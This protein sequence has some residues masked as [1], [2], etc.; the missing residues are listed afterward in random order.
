MNQ[1]AKSLAARIRRSLTVSTAFVLTVA[2]LAV[3]ELAPG[4]L[5]AANAA[6]GS[7]TI[8]NMWTDMQANGG[9]FA[10]GANSNGWYDSSLR[11]GQAITVDRNTLYTGSN[12]YGVGTLPVDANGM[13]TSAAVT[14]LGATS[15]NTGTGTGNPPDP[16]GGSGTTSWTSTIAVDANALNARPN[17]YLYAWNYTTDLGNYIVTALGTSGVK[18]IPSTVTQG[19]NGATAQALYRVASGGTAAQYTVIPTPAYFGQNVSSPNTYTY[20]SGGEAVQQTGDIMFSGA[21][22]TCLSSFPMMEFDPNNGDYNFSAGIQP[23]SPADNI[24]GT[25]AASCGYYNGYVAS[26]MALDA[27]GN[28]YLLV[29]SNA[30]VPA[31]KVAANTL[32]TTWMVKIIPSTDPG[33]PW[34]YQLVAPISAAPGQ[35]GTAVAVGSYGS[36]GMAFFNGSLYVAA[37]AGTTLARVNPMS[38]QAYNVP[39]GAAASNFTVTGGASAAAT[40]YDLA[41]GQTAYVIQGQVYNDADGNGSVSDP[42][43]SLLPGQTV[44]LYMKDPN[45]GG[46]WTYEGSRITNAEGDY[47]FLVGGQGEYIVRLV[48]PQINGVNAVQ[49]WADAGSDPNTATVAQCLNDP[50][51]NLTASNGACDGALA[52]PVAD[53]ALPTS[54]S[55]PG[56]DTSTQ[57]GQ[58]P[59]YSTVTMNSDQEVANADFGVTTAGSYGDA[60]IAPTTVAA[61]APV[62]LNGSAEPQQ[63]WLGDKL[64][65][66]A[67]PATDNSHASTDDGLYVKTPEGNLPLVDNTM[68]A[69]TRSYDVLAQV[70]GGLATNSNVQAEAWTT[71][72]GGTAWNNT[73]IWSPTIDSSQVASGQMQVS[74]TSPG[75]S[76]APVTVRAEVSI[77]ATAL[78]TN[79]NNEYQAS[80]SSTTQAWA[81][82]GE[83]EDNVLTAADSV[84]RPVAVTTN[85]SG[86]FTVGGQTLTASTTPAI[87]AGKAAVGGTP[88]SVTAEAASGWA[89]DSVT[90]VNT[91]SN[92]TDAAPTATTV[93]NADG[94]V[95]ITWTPASADDVE[96]VATYHELANPATSTL[97][98][99]KTTAT[100]NAP[101]TATATLLG[102]DGKPLAGSTVTFTG[103]SATTPLTST[104]GVSLATTPLTCTTDDTGTCSVT[105]TSATAGTFTGELHATVPDDAGVAQDIVNSPATVSFTADIGYPATSSLSVTPAGPLVVTDTANNTYTATATI[106]DKD[107]NPSGGQTVTF[108]V[109][110]ADG[111]AIDTSKTTLSASTC[112]TGDGTGSDPLGQCS[113]TLTS[114]QAGTFLIHAQIATSATDPTLVDVGSAAS[115]ATSSPATVVFKPGNLCL[116]ENGCTTGGTKV[117]VFPDGQ[118]VTTPGQPVTPENQDVITATATDADGNPIGGVVFTFAPRA[119]ATVTLSATSCTTGDGTGGTTLGQCTVTATSSVA[120]NPAGPTMGSD[121]VTVIVPGPHLVDASVTDPGSGDTTALTAKSGSPLPLNF[122]AGGV[123]IAEAGCTGTPSTVAVSVDNMQVTTPGQAPTADNQDVVIGTAHDANGNLVGGVEFDFSTTDATLTLSGTTCTTNSDMSSPDYG[124]CSVTATST[125]SGAHTDAVTGSINDAGTVTE[126]TKS[127]SPLT[128]NFKPGGVCIQEAGCTGSPSYVTVYPD[129]ALADGTDTDVI[130]AYA[131]DANG[132]PKDGVQ[133]VFSTADKDLSLAATSCTTGDGTN[134]TTLGQCTVTATSTVATNASGPVYGTD[135][136]TVVVPGPHLVTASISDSGTLTELTK[137]G[138]PAPLNFHAGT[139]TTKD[140]SLSLSASSAISGGSVTATVTAKDSNGNLVPNTAITLQVG[141]IAPATSMSATVGGATS[142]T[143]NTGPDGQCSA[144]VTDAASETVNV[145]GLLGTDIA[146]DN[147]ANSPASVEFGSGPVSD[148]YSTLTVAPST[149][150]AGSPVIVTVTAKD[151]AGNTIDNLT[152]SQITVTGTSAGLPDLVMTDFANLGN[153]VYQYQTT[154]DLV[155]TFTFKAVVDGVSLT[156]TMVNGAQATGY[157]TVLFTAGDVCVSNCENTGDNPPPGTDPT[158]VTRFTVDP[159]GS[160]A[161]GKSPSTV[162]AWAYD[163]YGNAVSG[164]PVVVTDTTTGPL[165]GKLTQTTPNPVDTSSDGT[166]HVSFVTTTAGTYQALGTIGGQK[167]SSAVVVLSFVPGN[168]SPS[169]SALT[170]SQNSQ[171]AGASVTAQ[172][173][174]NDAGGNAVGGV[175]VIVSSDSPDVYFDGDPAQ[176][177]FICTTAASGTSVGTCDVPF[178]SKTAG[179]YRITAVIAETNIGGSPAPVSFT[180]GQ[181][182]FTNC[183]PVDGTSYTSVVMTKDGAMGNGTDAN[184]ATASVFD[185]YGNPVAGATVATTPITSTLSAATATAT[186]GKDGTA[187]LAYTSTAVG[188]AQASVTIDGTEPTGPA[189]ASDNSGKSP[190]TMTFAT[191]QADPANSSLAI[192][193]TTSQEVDSQF[194]VTATVN[195]SANHPVTGAVVTFTADAGATLS[196]TTCTT[197]ADGT[198]TVDVSATKVGTYKVGATIPNTA[199]V[200]TALKS[201]PVSATFTAGPVCVQPACTPD[202]GVPVTSV[203]VT[204]N[205]QANDGTSRDV[206]TVYAY[207][208]HGNPVPGA[209]VA[210]TSSDSGLVIQPDIAKTGDNGQSSIW[211]ASTVAGEHPADVTVAGLTPPTSPISLAFGNGVGCAACSSFAVAPNGPLTVG[212]SDANTYTVT[213]TVNDVFNKP[214]SGVTVSFS[215]D[216]AGPVWAGNQATCV[217]VADGTCSVKVS[218]TKAGTFNVSAGLVNPTGTALIG[219]AQPVTWKADAVCAE[220]CTPVDPTLSADLRTRVVVLPENDY[221]L[222]DG[223]ARDIATVYAFDQYGNPVPAVLVKSTSSDSGLTIQSAPA[224][225]NGQGVT[226]IWYSSTVAGAHTADVTLADDATSAV[227]TPAGSP[228]TLNFKTGGL[229]AKNSVLSV[230]PA[231]QT[232][233]AP[234]TVSIVAKDATNNP[235]TGL[236]AGQFAVTGTA[237]GLPDLI[238]G[239]WSD[240]GGG[241]YT[242]QTTSYLDGTFTL[243]ATVDGVTLLQTPTATFTSGGVCVSNCENTGENP[244]PGTDPTHV[245]RFEVTTDNQVANGTSADVVTAWAYDTYGNAVGTATSGAKV[246]LTDQTG[247]P[248]NGVLTPGTGTGT[249]GAGG[250]ATVSFTSVKSGQFQA[251]GTIDGLKPATGVVVMNFVPANVSASASRL[252]VSPSTQTAG[253]SVTAHV[254]TNDANGN[255]VGGVTVDLSSNSPDVYFNNDQAQ[256]TWTC[257]TAPS[258]ANLGTCDVPVTSKVAG[259]YKVSATI[260]STQI[261]G[262][263]APVTFTAGTVCYADCTPVDGTSYTKVVMTKDGA[264]DDGTD[265]NQATAYA[266]DQYGNPVSGA[267]VATSPITS[268]LKAAKA[269]AVTAGDGTAVLSYTSMVAGPASAAVTINGTAPSDP[270]GP[271]PVSMTFATGVGDPAHSSVAISPATSQQVDSTFTVTA[272]VNDS[273]DQPVTD[274]V[275]SF[276]ADAGA[277]LSAATCTTATDGTCSVTVTATKTGTYKIHATIPNAAGAPT[278]VQNS[279]VS[280]VFTAGPVCLVSAGCTPDQGVPVTS[281]VVTI[282]GVANDGVARDIATVYA[283]DKHGNAVP[284]APVASTSTS[285]ALT[286]Q[287]NVPNTDA[288]GQSTVWYT[289]TTAGSFPADVTVA[290]GAPEGSPVSLAFGNGL[291]YA[292]NSSFSVTPIGP[293]TVGTGAANTYTVTAVVN[294]V[295]NKP[296]AGAVASFAISPT[297]PAWANGQTCVTGDGTNGTTLGQCSVTVSSTKSGTF[298]VTAALGADPIGQAESVVWK[299]DAVCASDCTPVDPNLPADQR[300]RVAVTLDNQLADGAAQDIATLYAFDEYGNPV[301]GALVQSTSSD[302]GLLIQSAPAGTNDHGVTTIWY[303]SKVAG[304]HTADVTVDHKV[305]AGSPVTVN[306]KAGAVDAQASS[307]V[308]SPSTQKVTQNVTVTV[309]TRDANGNVTGGVPVKLAVTGAATLSAS[310][311]TTDATTGICQVTLTD[312]TPEQVQVSATIAVNG[313]DTNVGGSPAAVTFTNGC[314][315]GI[316]ADCQY[317]PDVTNDHRTNVQVTTDHQK[318]GGAGTDVATVKVFDEYGIAVAGVAVTST[319]TESELKISSPIAATDATG[320][321]TI[322]YTS[323]TLAPGAYQAAVMA[324]GVEIKFQP[325]PVPP[326]TVELTDDQVKALSSPVTLNFVDVTPPAKPVVITPKPGEYINTGTPTVSGTAEPGSVVAVTV[327]GGTPVCTAQADDKGTWS[328][329]NSGTGAIPMTDGAHTISVTAADVSGNVS[330]ATEVTFTVDTEAP[331]APKVNPTDGTE[332]SGSAEP[333]TTINVTDDAGNTIPGCES[334]T[335]AADTGAFSC[336]PAIPLTPGTQVH[337][338]ATDE[339]GNVSPE[340][341]VT[342]MPPLVPQTKVATG[343]TVVP[344][345]SVAGLGALLIAGVACLMGVVARRR[346]IDS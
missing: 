83:I 307:L 168:V 197:L 231:T 298:A 144:D 291:G 164:V 123:C 9:N 125:V 157:P 25:S 327:D 206:A 234:V 213:A 325:Q 148:R 252:T 149:Q 258:G 268:T 57:P 311:C 313:T 122:T 246:V 65:V 264:M 239:S 290:G 36:W 95:T 159:N 40:T 126:L 225:T 145:Y 75:T 273:S 110:N 93:T 308:A 243:G 257:L 12:Y 178:T 52:M 181:P 116:Q 201:S 68:V 4:A 38:G 44:A 88:V 229:S 187:V 70:N 330:G 309:T 13:V 16:T 118:Q 54:A 56:S 129:N 320:A 32:G 135:G 136:T 248:L 153:G 236:T 131:V 85:G 306:F 112:T 338:T 150:T 7:H 233:G 176:T 104:T 78:P 256:T 81:T 304:A 191:G 333:G 47:S 282:N 296:V 295:F 341:V 199:G 228:V 245:T 194:T 29:T 219:S 301:P 216:N 46:Q 103:N 107:S 18:N 262:S 198:C 99:D 151:D 328:C 33:T 92:D 133:F 287:S 326:A 249:T 184:E 324:K 270:S 300:T 346:R 55:A 214:A 101:I 210:S 53:P 77:G 28:A 63:L 120:T 165:A 171:T 98:L 207:D 193:P 79:A 35:G 302:A 117:A 237:A 114:T 200:D 124:T 232:A 289:S 244:P 284:D 247:A 195:D 76:T 280:A 142:M 169:A 115:P 335:A 220:G 19:G 100:V 344:G 317:Q 203:T 288:A 218:S 139:A 285:S 172:V 204:V 102:Y 128:L 91:D 205:G 21:E 250:T 312:S 221:Q 190:V 339:A 39:A 342:V 64:G 130:T 37:N 202:A 211:Y 31:F 227:K 174:T 42:G 321:S 86:T 87:G 134:G 5:S 160:V 8:G 50:N 155:G 343:G 173:V 34:T 113:V 137:N 332:I 152:A 272:T 94:S 119:D 45:N 154:S 297:G 182:C 259:D 1:Q 80:P 261:G 69:A 275:V 111:S 2:G 15:N 230:S 254:T 208:K 266:Y 279:P 3:A 303:A 180:A 192:A 276:G 323:T 223:I 278:N 212:T 41:S 294:D 242:Y 314:L 71:G 141:P 17:A 267:S 166:A 315:P 60:N 215:L 51:D 185:Q 175:D 73:A 127:G 271:S 97:S 217:T 283:Y 255:L 66:Y 62:H 14:G 72:L 26:D 43:D 345:H 318:A 58:M 177:S 253:A 67:G 251:E 269:S 109:A 310:I 322:A 6:I 319:T 235:I 27:S 265:V 121:G 59:I 170:L 336:I 30:A 96:V 163:T 20:W 240:L 274:A 156:Q 143:C 222:A 146:T 10:T 74:T 140:S 340:T 48:Q 196:A 226:T 305:P 22:L 299:A 334:V 138:S 23:A 260:A 286:V 224:G 329:S 105:F 89:I 337:V 188:Q 106:K 147:I 263:P 61:G 277:S 281:V 84:Y 158:H 167:P 82:P 241:T 108:S 183:T 238:L 331:A 186:T 11:L 209:A 24:F 132:N 189:G 161:D 293:L 179:S 162:N 316:D 49:T 90:L 292:P